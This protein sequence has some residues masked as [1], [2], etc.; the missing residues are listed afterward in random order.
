MQLECGRIIRGYPHIFT[1]AFVLLDKEQFFIIPHSNF[2]C[3]RTYLRI[4]GWYAVPDHP[5]IFL[6]V[7]RVHTTIYGMRWWA[8]S[9][10]T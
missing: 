4:Q 8:E 6:M 9:Q 7:R 10:E 1:Q 3:A 2:L 5:A